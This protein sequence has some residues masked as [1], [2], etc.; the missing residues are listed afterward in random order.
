MPEPLTIALGTAAALLSLRLVRSL[1][2]VATADCDLQTF[3]AHVRDDTFRGKVAWVTG[4]SSG[5]GRALA[6][7]L[8]ARR[9]DVLRELAREL[10]PPPPMPSATGAQ[11]KGEGRVVAVVPLDLAQDA[12]TL[13]AVARAVVAQ[14]GGRVDFLFNNAGVSARADGLDVHDTVIDSVMHIN[15]TSRSR[16][17]CSPPARRW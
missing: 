13:R 11:G 1:V 9:E 7:A 8:A 6:H 17:P 2:R 4:A 15:Y 16:R 14:M 12:E 10:A 5:I 3:R